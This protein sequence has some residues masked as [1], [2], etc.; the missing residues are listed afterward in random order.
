MRTMFS[1]KATSKIAMLF[2]SL[3]VITLYSCSDDQDSY[4]SNGQE[5]E[6]A[7]QLGY[8]PI[9]IVDKTLDF[10]NQSGKLY[11]SVTHF[12]DSGVIV[13]NST[14]DYAKYP[15]T[16]AYQTVSKNGAIY[17]LIVTKATY[18]PYYNITNYSEF[19]FAIGFTFTSASSGVY[20]GFETNASGEDKKISGTFT[21]K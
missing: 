1:S 21:I 3:C 15:P 5:S 2:L 14:I 4:R 17:N 20:E 7:Q 19:S 18:I 11:L 6:S 8:A 12:E 13:N 16:Y 10:T 9:N